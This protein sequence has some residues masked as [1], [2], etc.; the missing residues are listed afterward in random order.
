MHNR[1]VDGKTLNIEWSHKSR[2]N[3]S[4]HKHSSRGGDNRGHGEIDCFL[5]GEIGHMAKECKHQ[6]KQE[7]GN[8]VPFDRE[9]VIDNLRKERSRSRTRLRSPNRYTQAQ[10]R[11]YKI[12][13]ALS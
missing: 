9:A 12:I 1:D 10:S 2:N 11:E 3:G 5:C 6:D 13:K 4:G 7:E 8:N